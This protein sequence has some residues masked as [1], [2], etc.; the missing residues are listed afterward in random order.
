MAGMMGSNL[1]GLTAVC[2]ESRMADLKVV[3]L[4]SMMA[5]TTGSNLVEWKA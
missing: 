2:L 1:A 5:E 3:C 4:E